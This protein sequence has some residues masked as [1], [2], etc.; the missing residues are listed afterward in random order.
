MP[1]FTSADMKIF[2]QWIGGYCADVRQRALEE[3]IGRRWMS[4]AILSDLVVEKPDGG[5]KMLNRAF[6]FDVHK[7][8][9][10]VFEKEMIVQSGNA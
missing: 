3:R 6:T 10:G 9:S 4:G 7:E 2:I 8:Q 1:L 5:G